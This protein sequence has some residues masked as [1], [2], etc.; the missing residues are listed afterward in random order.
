MDLKDIDEMERREKERILMRRKGEKSKEY[1]TEQK[2][3]RGRKRGRE[4]DGE[5]DSKRERERNG[6]RE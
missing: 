3:N 6:E 1:W 2:K 5:R 4:R